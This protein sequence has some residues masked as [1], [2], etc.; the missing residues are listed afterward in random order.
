SSALRIP[1]LL[2][3]VS[4]FVDWAARAC[5]VIGI[6]STIGLPTLAFFSTATYPSLHNNAAYWFFMLETIAIFLNTYVSYRLVKSAKV[7]DITAGEIP[8]ISDLEDIDAETKLYGMQQTL[9]LQGVCSALFFVAF[10]LYLP[11]GLTVVQPFKRLTIAQCLERDLGDTYCTMTMRFDDFYT[12]LWNYEDD[13]SATQMRAGAQ[14]TCILTL[15]G[16]SI[17]FLT[18]DMDVLTKD[19]DRVATFEAS[20]GIQ[21]NNGHFCVIPLLM[22]PDRQSNT[23]S[24]TDFISSTKTQ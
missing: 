8:V 23:R 9:R 17:S 14:L 2:G 16:Y 24:S 6:I 3:S 11:I 22:S 18:H 4:P 20:T 1:T 15:V 19:R 5:T 12:K 7:P 13:Y 21:T 10:L